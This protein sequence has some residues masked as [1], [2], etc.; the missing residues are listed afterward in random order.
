MS[1][2]LGR[3]ED[4][5]VRVDPRAATSAAAPAPFGGALAASGF[6]NAGKNESQQ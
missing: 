2:R 1:G 6:S 3:I 4:R 5:R